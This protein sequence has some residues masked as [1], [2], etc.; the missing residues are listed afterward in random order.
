[1]LW[2]TLPVVS[3]PVFRNREGLGNGF[4]WTQPPASRAVEYEPGDYPV[5]A[6][7]LDSSICVGDAL[8]PL[9]VQP[10][11]VMEGYVEGLRK[12]LAD[13]ERLI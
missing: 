8:H 3:S 11:E 1:M 6:R 4:P 5:A 12:V 9:F 2:H 7:T 10:I 13:P